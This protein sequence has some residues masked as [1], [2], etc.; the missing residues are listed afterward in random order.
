MKRLFQLGIVA[1]AVLGTG[2]ARASEAA[3]RPVPV[4]P[5]HGRPAVV[6]LWA[7][8]F[9][10]RS[11]FS[12]FEATYLEGAFL[13]SGD[14]DG[15]GAHEIV[16]G[17]GP[18]RRAEIRMYTQEGKLLSVRALYPSW[19]KGGI[20]VAVGDVDGDGNAE[21]M[22]APGPGIEPLVY[23]LDGNGEHAVPGGKLA[24]AKTFQGGLR[25]AAG[26]LD[27]DG[28]AEIVTA[29]G[30]GGGPH[31]RFFNGNLEAK[32]GDIFAFDETMRDGVSL[33][34]LRTA[35]GN[36]LAVSPESWSSSVVRLFDGKTHEQIV[37][38]PVFAVASRNGTVI[39]AFDFDGDGFDEIA[40]A[41][42]GG[43]NAEVRVMSLSGIVLGKFLVQDPAY[44]GAL[45]M[46]QVG[47]GSSR[48]LATV[49]V[50]PLIK[51]PTDTE[52]S[53][54]VNLTEQRLYAY[55]R[56]RIARTF[57]IS[58][59]TSRFPTPEMKTTVLTKVPVKTY[60]WSYGVNHPDNYNLSGVKWNLQ[61]K[62]PYYIHHAYWH[63]N[64]GN[65]MSHGCV[66]VG[67]ADSE[68]IYNWSEVGTPVQT[69]YKHTSVELVSATK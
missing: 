5:E 57:L 21:I 24:Y 55:E 30:P 33:A 28:K 4:R 61:I 36:A 44:R 64:F 38:R 52:K 18:G 19:F 32:E 2:F 9:K 56:G 40:A 50:A 23:V 35:S 58:S 26:D 11:S 54:F 37:E 6:S 69:A 42:N 43:T 49:A 1:C 27:G 16:V 63:N 66:N 60:R 31:I 39:A 62:G 67:T 53:I 20:R 59:G 8:E 65:R 14:L 45:S 29:P 51:G 13:A 22:T 3:V 41:Q 68:W 17:S 47:T 48:R 7:P 10:N 15:D 12:T 25:I 46:A 34:I